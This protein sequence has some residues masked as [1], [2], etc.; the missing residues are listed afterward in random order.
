MLTLEEA[1]WGMYKSFL[2]YL[3]NSPL[4]FFPDIKVLK[5][6]RMGY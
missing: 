3:Y 6:N 5:K 2:Y 1:G 4:K